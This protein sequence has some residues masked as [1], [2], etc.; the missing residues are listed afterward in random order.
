MQTSA[1]RSGTFGSKHGVPRQFHNPREFPS[2]GENA[3][4][5]LIRTLPQSRLTS[6]SP[7]AL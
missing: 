7:Q 4:A 6:C 2:K 5:M 1:R 3:V